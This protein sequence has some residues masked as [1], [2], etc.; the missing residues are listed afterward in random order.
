M[1][2][3]MIYARLL[4]ATPKIAKLNNGIIANLSDFVQAFGPPETHGSNGERTLFWNFSSNRESPKYF[5]ASCCVPSGVDL[6]GKITVDV[7]TRAAG[8]GAEHF[9][10]W[11]TDRHLAVMNN[12]EA[13][14]FIVGNGPVA[15]L[16]RP[17][18]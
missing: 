8:R 13:P 2:N 3:Q 12:V 5:T 17:T 9:F 16:D 18:V 10:N 1:K 4:G 11:F 14:Q 15:V 7:R 6:D